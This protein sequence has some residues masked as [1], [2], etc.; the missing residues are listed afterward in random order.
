[1]TTTV[2]VSTTFWAAQSRAPLT[3]EVRL[4]RAGQRDA[5][6]AVPRRGVVSTLAYEGRT[7]GWY[8]PDR[9]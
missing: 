2:G 8:S 1:M 3:A 4:A 7:A 5:Y 6:P 9:Y